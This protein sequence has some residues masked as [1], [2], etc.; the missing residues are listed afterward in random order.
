MGQEWQSGRADE[1]LCWRSE[2]VTPV[3][4][5]RPAAYFNLDMTGMVDAAYGPATK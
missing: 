2:A 5:E 1:A 3:L 4:G